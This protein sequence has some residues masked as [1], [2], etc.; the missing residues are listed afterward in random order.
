MD[1]KNEKLQRALARLI[2][3]VEQHCADIVDV[4]HDSFQPVSS[5]V[6]NEM[7][8]A[9]VQIEDLAKDLDHLALEKDWEMEHMDRSENA[10]SS[11]TE[12]ELLIDYDSELN[13]NDIVGYDDGRDYST[14]DTYPY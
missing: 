14:D 13:T 2:R 11:Q 8:R 3:V 9:L 1:S 6:I 10:E 7:N 5:P 12:D 4:V